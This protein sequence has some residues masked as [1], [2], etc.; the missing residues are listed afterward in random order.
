MV[1]VSSDGAPKRAVSVSDSDVTWPNIAER[2][3]RPNPMPVREPKY[4]APIATIP[5][6]AVT[7]SI[8]MPSRKISAVSPAATPSSMIAALTVG[9]YSEASELRVC[10]TSTAATGHRYGRR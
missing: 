6:R 3:S 7:A 9:R 4:T 1:R 2:R 5:C 8:T 10:S